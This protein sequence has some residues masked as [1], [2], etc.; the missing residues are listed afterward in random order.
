MNKK[1]LGVDKANQ[2]VQKANSGYMIANYIKIIQD[3]YFCLDEDELVQVM[4][5]L[6]RSKVSNGKRKFV[7]DVDSL[8]NEFM[9][10]GK[11]N[12]FECK[13]KSFRAD[14]NLENSLP[15]L[16][17]PGVKQKMERKLRQS[18]HSDSIYLYDKLEGRS[19]I[20]NLLMGKR[21]VFSTTDFVTKISNA[22]RYISLAKRSLIDGGYAVK[23]P[24]LFNRWNE[25]IVSLPDQNIY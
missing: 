5:R 12:S 22:N 23:S 7:I 19:A 10:D 20:S 21:P 3:K 9:N 25:L 16:T 6:I 17:D 14:H 1:I 24:Q 11:L 4:N 8:C 13:W 18:K 15:L 2:L